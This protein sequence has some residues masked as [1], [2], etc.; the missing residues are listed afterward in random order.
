MKTLAS[1]LTLIFIVAAG[2]VHGEELEQ[3]QG[4]SFSLGP[5]TGVAYYVRTEAGYKVIATL[6]AGETGTPMR[7]AATLLAGQTLEISVP[8][9]VGEAATALQIARVGDSLTV[10]GAD[11]GDFPPVRPAVHKL[12]RSPSAP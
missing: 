12:A 10:T 2:A 4:K 8:N 11:Q 1:T 7:V 6:A 5:L 3:M 9:G